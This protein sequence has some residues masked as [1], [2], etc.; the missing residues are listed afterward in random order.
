M[1]AKKERK[2]N[3]H[4]NSLFFG[5]FFLLLASVHILHVYLLEGP[6]H[7]AIRY[8]IAQALLQTIVEAGALCIFL[9]L[10][11]EYSP[12]WT[13]KL[14]IVLVFF[15]FLAQ[16]IDFPFVRLMD[17]SVWFVF[18]FLADETFENFLEMLY[19]SNVTILSWIFGI[20]FFVLLLICALFFYKRTSEWSKKVP[21]SRRAVG[22]AAAIALAALFA[23]DMGYRNSFSSHTY[24][25][26]SAALPWKQTLLRTDSPLHRSV[27][28]PAHRIPAEAQ[29]GKV[30]NAYQQSADATPSIFLFIVE[31]LRED[32]VE[33]A[34]APHLYSFKQE[35]THLA[36]T[37]SNSNATQLSW[38]S[39]FYSKWPF[40]FET[41]KPSQWKSGS[42]PL[43]AL[44]KLGYSIHVYTSARL[45]YYQMDEILF[46]AGR[47][48]MDSYYESYSPDIAPAESDRRA[49]EK[50]AAD[51]KAAPCKGARLNIIF[52]DATHFDYS[53]PKSNMTMFQPCDP[54]N[55]LS[56][57]LSKSCT[58]PIKN[59]YKNA[60]HYI[61]FLI[62]N[63][64]EDLKRLQLWEQSAIVVTGDHGEEFYEQGHLFHASNLS[65][66]QLRVPIYYKF[67][68]Q[69]N[70]SLPLRTS[71]SH[72]DIFP[73]LLHYLSKNTAVQ[74]LVEGESIFTADPNPFL[75]S[76]RYNASRSPYEFSIHN[77]R[78]KLTAR[79]DALRNIMQAK[80]LFLISLKNA[81]DQELPLSVDMVEKEFSASL[82]KIFIKP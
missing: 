5:F 11:S 81:E 34:T 82:K 57:T 19:A 67:P 48:L 68:A 14:G 12:S 66:P 60:L 73:T 29:V 40:F 27:D 13:K 24:M 50:L 10:L 77:L 49:L 80:K 41:Y 9:S 2:K 16:I 36:W 17:M 71:T 55:Y 61:D 3:R 37:L 54:I 15:F 28:F 25:Q 38:F 18:H 46:G 23:I 65:L 43:Q 45:Q 58:T 79:F 1:H 44:K 26:Y 52:L 33:R 42:I 39:I 35:N 32:F 4:V 72:I 22:A 63:L 64:F 6:S 51:L 53:W 74:E 20:S 30:L 75:I 56:A 76:A 31:S 69:E 21:V 62:G 8:F 59:R 70:P 47:N 78:Y 7:T